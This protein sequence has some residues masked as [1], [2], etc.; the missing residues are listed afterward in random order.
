MNFVAAPGRVAE[1]RLLYTVGYDPESL[2]PL[3]LFP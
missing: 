1:S 3:H 2:C